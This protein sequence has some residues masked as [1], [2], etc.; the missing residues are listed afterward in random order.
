MKLLLLEFSPTAHEGQKTKYK[1][2]SA[3]CILPV[4]GD[5]STPLSTGNSNNNNSVEVF[6]Y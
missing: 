2:Y 4:V 1:K 6:C 3:I 5:T